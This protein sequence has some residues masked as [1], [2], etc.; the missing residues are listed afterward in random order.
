MQHQALRIDQNVPLLALDLLARIIS[1]RIDVG[2]AFFRALDALRID[3]CHG[4]TGFPRG[5]FSTFDVERVVDALQ[6]PVP[7]PAV[8]VV[9]HCAARR[10]VLRDC[11][12]LT[13]G[14]EAGEE[15]W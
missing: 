5:L 4:R 12:P 10:Q 9:M 11:T 2:T 6:R 7:A 15:K 3:N 13:A 14:A 1:M 8:E